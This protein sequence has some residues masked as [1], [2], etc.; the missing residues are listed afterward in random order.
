MNPNA[1][2][3]KKDD[4]IRIYTS[5]Q[6]H[7]VV[8]VGA[9]TYVRSKV[10]A[11]PPAVEFGQLRLNDLGNA[12]LADV[13]TQRLIVYDKG[14]ADFKIQVSSDLPFLSMISRP[15]PT[16]DRFEVFVTVDPAKAAPG[17]Y[18]GNLQIVTNDSSVPKLTVPVSIAVS[19]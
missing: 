18:S 15:A 19:K 11:F 16:G 17:T 3:G 12:K 1:A 5:S 14:R 2:L 7:P 8:N 6:E 13:L 4:I 9:H 10:Y